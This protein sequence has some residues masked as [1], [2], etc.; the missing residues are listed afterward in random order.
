MIGILFLLSFINLSMASDNIASCFSYISEVDSELIYSKKC[1]KNIFKTVKY[2]TVKE[3][4]F[5]IIPFKNVLIIKGKTSNKINVI[6][7]KKTRFTNITKVF[8]SKKTDHA[9]IVNKDQDQVE[10]LQANLNRSGNVRTKILY[11]NDIN[12]VDNIYQLESNST[13]FI[14]EG[15]KVITLEMLNNPSSKDVANKR[16]LGLLIQ[17]Q[18]II[19]SKIVFA[20]SNYLAFLNETN[21]A[22]IV[23]NTLNNLLYNATINIED[24]KS[25]IFTRNLTEITIKIK[26]QVL[27]TSV[28]GIKK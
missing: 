22:L 12:I 6:Y 18:K 10:I 23:L 7:G 5:Q 14:K 19:N 13:L 16:N 8:H 20:T 1:L 26:D 25:L 28:Q 11:S 21:G 9:L 17:N 24:Y 15:D 3:S 4:S 2:T 27:F